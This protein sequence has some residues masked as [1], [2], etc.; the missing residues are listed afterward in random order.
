VP[1]LRSQLA[2]EKP[3]PLRSSCVI[4]VSSKTRAPVLSA[5]RSSISSNCARFTFHV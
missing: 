5:W 4:R 1:S 3:S 2:A